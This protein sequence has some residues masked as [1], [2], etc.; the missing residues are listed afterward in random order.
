MLTLKRIA[1]IG[2]LLRQFLLLF[3]D[4]FHSTAG[5]TLMRTYVGGLLS[6]IQRKNCEAIA[7]TFGTAPRT[8]QRLL[9]SIQWDEQKLRDRTQQIIAQQHA[10]KEA[11][12]LIDESGIHKSGMHTAGAGRQYN[13]NLGKLD[14][15]V[16]GVH[17]SYSAP[18]FQCLLDSQ[19]YLPE[20]WADDRQKRKENYIPDDVVFQTKPQIAADQ[21]KRALA[22]GIVVSAWTF[23]ELYGRDSKFL[24]ELDALKQAFVGEIPRNFHGWTRNPKVIRKPLK[25]SKKKSQPRPAARVRKRDISCEVQNLARYSRVFQQQKWRRYKVKETGRGP[26]VWEVKWA[27]FWRKTSDKLPATEHTLI[28]ARNV[29]TG[30]IKYFLSNCVIGKNGVTLRWLLR[31]AFGRWAIEACFRTSKEE[32]GMDHFECRGW[33]CIHRHYF[34]TG[35]SFLFCSRLRQEWEDLETRNPLEKLT[36]EQVRTAVNVYLQNL[37]LPPALRESRY[38]VVLR[39]IA[40]HQKRNAQATASHTKTR[41]ELYQQ[42]GIDVDRI[43]S[44]DPKYENT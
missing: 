27:P 4:C 35:V 8:L 22:G 10:H 3:A 44:C 14:N 12:G 32:L 31:V 39:R 26:E 1:S 9:E 38:E 11:I 43:N 28:I 34:L 15:C 2:T 33:R 37:D 42:M 21:V 30:E 23:D 7:L 5:R 18:G 20:S 36:V 6:D 29:R 19:L 16:V 25:N 40:Y 17:L 13:G 24:D 41:R